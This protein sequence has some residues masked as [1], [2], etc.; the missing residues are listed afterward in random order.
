MYRG[1]A[2]VRQ[3][4][5]AMQCN[6]DTSR[7]EPTCAWAVD[8]L[9]VLGPPAM[10]VLPAR[11]AERIGQIVRAAGNVVWTSRTHQGIDSQVVSHD[12]IND[13]S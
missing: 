8:T 6:P 10:A 1:C 12:S 9:T 2:T 11:S 5:R 4:R 3:R 13:D 7:N